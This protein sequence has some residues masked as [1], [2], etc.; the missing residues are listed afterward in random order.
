MT[1]LHR[2]WAATVVGDVD[3]QQLADGGQL[4]ADRHEQ[5]FGLPVTVRPAC[6]GGPRPGHG[7][8]SRHGRPSSVPRTRAR[9]LLAGRVAAMPTASLRPCMSSSPA[10][11][12]ITAST[13]GRRLEARPWSETDRHSDRAEGPAV[14]GRWVHGLGRRRGVSRSCRMRGAG[15]RQGRRRGTAKLR[16][17]RRDRRRL[18]GLPPRAPRGRPV[19]RVS[20]RAGTLRA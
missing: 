14:S 12:S 10:T 6:G 18:G 20:S 7:A 1:L 5:L 4:D 9:T 2:G 16:R 3:D 8:T 17:P 13:S 11:T 15:L 19:G